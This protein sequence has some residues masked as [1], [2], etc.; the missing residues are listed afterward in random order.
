[1]MSSRFLT[2]SNHGALVGM[3]VATGMVWTILVFTIRI[4]IRLRIVPPFGIDDST[5]ALALSSYAAAILYIMA[6]A[7]SKCSTSLLIARLTRTKRHL[8]ASHSTTAFTLSWAFASILVIAVPS[9]YSEAR[10]ESYQPDMYTRWVVI[11]GFS[12]AIE[13]IIFAL[14]IYLV[15]SLYMPFKTK[16]VVVG[17]FFCRILIII[18]TA[19]RLRLLD[20]TIDSADLTY[21]SVN[22]TIVTQV[23]MHFSLMACTIPCMKQFLRAFDTDLGHT[24]NINQ[25]SMHSFTGSGKSRSQTHGGGYMLH[26]MSRSGEVGA[27]GRSVGNQQDKGV[28]EIQ[29]RPEK[30]VSRTEV[31]RADERELHEEHSFYSEGSERPI[32]RKTQ[33]WD[34]T[35]QAQQ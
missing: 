35:F 26:S 16:A 23:V 33:R 15:W 18:P 34:V 25:K 28:E 14:S 17:A 3:V 29:L 7:A 8:V 22:L 6:I 9:W 21:D 19:F 4:F 30:V 2:P 27:H 13:G 10:L 12:M 31:G 24:I 32:I 5:A 1:T 20:S 11:E